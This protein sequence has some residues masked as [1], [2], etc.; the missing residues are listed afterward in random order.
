M[1]AAADRLTRAFLH[2]Q[3]PALVA[4]LVQVLAW[5]ATFLLLSLSGDLASPA[6]MPWPILAQGLLA[7]GIAGWL[8]QP[9]WWQFIHLLFFPAVWLTGQARLDPVWFLGGLVLLSLTSI[10]ALRTRVPLFLSSH[11]AVTRLAEVLPVPAGGRVADLGCGLGGPLVHLARLRPDLFLHGVESAP[12]NWLVSRL[13]LGGKA[14][15]RLGS[16]WEEDLGR[17][18]AVYAYLS[19]APMARLWEKARREMRPGALFI[20]NSF[21]VPGIEPDQVIELDDL[22]HARLLVW[23]MA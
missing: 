6:P 2:R 8:G 10:G 4:L 21:A 13:R 9:S 19:P 20:S 16:L 14:S 11:Q 23:R 7:W 3:P 22:S 12:L 17:Y 18:D 15:V 1:P 5:G